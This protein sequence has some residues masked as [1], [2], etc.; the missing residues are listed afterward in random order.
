MSRLR[1]MSALAMR[2]T[3]AGLGW[4]AFLVSVGI[5]A[6]LTWRLLRLGWGIA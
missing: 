3:I 1:E 5:V 2:W 4:C 6:R